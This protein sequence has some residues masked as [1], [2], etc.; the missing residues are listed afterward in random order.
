MN[1]LPDTPIRSLSVN[2]RKAR[3]MTDFK[4]KPHENLG[5]M[6]LATD[7]KYLYFTWVEDFGNIWV[8][9]VGVK[10]GDWLIY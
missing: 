10:N 7:G 1:V 9:D 2:N 3:A 5:R 6:S 4:G 8:M